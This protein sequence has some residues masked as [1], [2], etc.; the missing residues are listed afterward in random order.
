MSKDHSYAL[1]S[2]LKKTLVDR[3]PVHRQTAASVAIHIVLDA[4]SLIY[5]DAMVH[6][7]ERLYPTLFDM[8]H[9]FT[10]SPE[11]DN[12]VGLVILLKEIAFEAVSCIQYE[13]T[14]VRLLERFYV[15]VLTP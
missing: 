7:L 5:E 3:D 14:L 10:I 13:S 11:I 8:S 12:L 4:V 1:K 2:H 6:L 15:H 9:S